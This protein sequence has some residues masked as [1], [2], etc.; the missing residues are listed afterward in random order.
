MQ[1]GLICRLYGLNFDT[2]VLFFNVK[3]TESVLQYQN[4]SRTTPGPFPEFIQCIDSYITH[5]YAD[6]LQI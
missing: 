4:M 6:S 3:Y 5:K 1:L 2:D